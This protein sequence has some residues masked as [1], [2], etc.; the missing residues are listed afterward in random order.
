M[1]IGDFDFRYGRG[2]GDNPA[3]HFVGSN[4]GITLSSLNG[5]NPFIRLSGKYVDGDGLIKHLEQFKAAIEKGTSPRILD[6][7]PTPYDSKKAIA[8]L[9]QAIDFLKKH[10]DAKPSDDYTLNLFE[11]GGTI[12][13]AAKKAGFDDGVR[14]GLNG[15][16]FAYKDKSGNDIGSLIF[17]EDGK[18]ASI[19]GT[20]IFSSLGG[21]KGV[22]N[23]QVVEFLKEAKELAAS[24]PKLQKML[25]GAIAHYQ[26]KKPDETARWNEK[27]DAEPTATLSPLAPTSPSGRGTER[28]GLK[29]EGPAAPTLPGSGSLSDYA[30][31]VDD[32]TKPKPLGELFNK[33]PEPPKQLKDLFRAG[34]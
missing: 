25:D 15:N 29:R 32:H 13:Q 21:K 3:W 19:T 5:K 17:T 2:N 6:G 4:G 11:P 27:F 34:R 28:S 7:V 18:Q 26:G 14:V 9:D 1:A 20:K 33:T 31:K 16:S 10:P 23:G 8:A 22:T 24:N 12:S 30:R